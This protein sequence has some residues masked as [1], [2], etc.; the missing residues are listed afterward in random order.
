MD[1]ER[2]QANWQHFKES[3]RERWVRISADEL[4]LIAGRRDVL[5]GQ[6][7]EVYRIAPEMA[8]TQ[9]ESW[10]AQQREPEAANR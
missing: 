2:I 4:D 3:A 9:V 10:Q 8:R 1:W 7:Q 6:I 5:V